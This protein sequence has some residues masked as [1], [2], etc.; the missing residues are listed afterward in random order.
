MGCFE[1]VAM[2]MLRSRQ[3]LRVGLVVNARVRVPPYVMNS[4]QLEHLAETQPEVLERKA[5]SACMTLLFTLCLEIHL[6]CCP[7]CRLLTG[8][9]LMLATGCT[10]ASRAKTLVVLCP[11]RIVPRSFYSTII[12]PHGTDFEHSLIEQALPSLVCCH[13]E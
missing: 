5:N 9:N 8:C 1:I 4:S 13:C 12:D 2:F 7:S 11:H 6:L 10:L 3:V